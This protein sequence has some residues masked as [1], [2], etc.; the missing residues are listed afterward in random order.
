MNLGEHKNSV[1]SSPS[2][3]ST[4]HWDGR[5]LSAFLLEAAHVEHKAWC[6]VREIGLPSSSSP[7]QSVLLNV[8][9]Q[10]HCW[11]EMKPI[12]MASVDGDLSPVL[13]LAGMS[14]CAHHTCAECARKCQLNRIIIIKMGCYRPKRWAATRTPKRLKTVS[15]NAPQ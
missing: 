2:V 13:T 3:I 10:G 4:Y 8:S 11:T 15:P 7:A 1:H 6:E 5:S 9:A 14:D 12:C